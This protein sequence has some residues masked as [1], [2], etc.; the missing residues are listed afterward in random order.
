MNAM[1]GELKEM[2]MRKATQNS[3]THRSP[4]DALEGSRRLMR[5]PGRRA[6]LPSLSSPAAD[7][8][9]DDGKATVAAA[10]LGGQRGH[11]HHHHF[12]LHDG[13]RAGKENKNQRE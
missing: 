8:E 1:R 4:V 13:L 6:S 5:V 3:Q 7:D 12:Q 9:A 10:R 11:L 2:Q